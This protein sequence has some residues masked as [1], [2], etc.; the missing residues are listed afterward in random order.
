MNE[1]HTLSHQLGGWDYCGAI[2][3]MQADIT[4]CISTSSMQSEYEKEFVDK[5]QSSKAKKKPGLASAKRYNQD[6]SQWSKI[7]SGQAS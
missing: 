3:V 7:E 1:V 2:Y 6:R 5:F 4:N